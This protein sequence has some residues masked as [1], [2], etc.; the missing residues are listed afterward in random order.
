MS[1]DPAE[2]SE[3]V[4]DGATDDMSVGGTGRSEAADLQ[5]AGRDDEI[6][7]PAETNDRSDA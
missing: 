5:Q 1:K 4:M 7:L 6:E 2:L 3:P